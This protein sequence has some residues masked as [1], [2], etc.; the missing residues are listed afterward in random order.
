MTF[1]AAGDENKTY[2]I[3]PGDP[4]F[5]IQSKFT[6]SRR[7][8][9]EISPKCPQGTA[10]FIADAMSMGYLIPVATITERERMFMGLANDK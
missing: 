2:T 7:A 8:S 10:Q 3:R 9:I 5:I 6:I 4:D 1:I